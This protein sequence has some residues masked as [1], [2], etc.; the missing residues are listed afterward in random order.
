MIRLILFLLAV[1][2]AIL[3]VGDDSQHNAVDMLRLLLALTFSN[4]RG[5]FFFTGI[6]NRRHSPID[7]HRLVTN[8][9]LYALIAHVAIY[10]AIRA[11]KYKKERKTSPLKRTPNICQ[12]KRRS[13]LWVFFSFRAEIADIAPFLHPPLFDTCSFVSCIDLDAHL[14]DVCPPLPN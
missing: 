6:S 8:G 10:E 13:F 9:Q 5:F 3:Y 12:I 7:K 1:A 2:S 11:I 4:A 14:V